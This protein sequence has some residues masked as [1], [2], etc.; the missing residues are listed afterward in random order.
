MNWTDCRVVAFD[1][2]TTGLQA[3]SGDRIIEFGAVE[4]FLDENANIIRTQEH[5]Y[6]INPGIPIPRE[7]SKVSGLYDSDV[8][9]S[10]F[11]ID[12]QAA[13]DPS[14]RR[15]FGGNSN[16]DKACVKFARVER[17]YRVRVQS[18]TRC[19]WVDWTW[20]SSLTSGE[21][22][23]RAQGLLGECHRAVHDA[24]ACGEVF[25]KMTKNF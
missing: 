19:S 12:C 9:I 18:W 1:T 21:D 22:R 15:D 25:I 3:Y 5:Q 14:L 10:S 8:A 16:F 6:L 24:R 13:V 2:E 4:F 7:A 20:S 17:V 11:R 23:P